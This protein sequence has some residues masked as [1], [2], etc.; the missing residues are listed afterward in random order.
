[1]YS[2]E[3]NRIYAT[4]EAGY[5]AAQVHGFAIISR[6]MD[7]LWDYADYELKYVMSDRRYWAP[8]DANA[9]YE[10]ITDE[11]SDGMYGELSKVWEGDAILEEAR[12]VARAANHQSAGPHR[13]LRPL[14][15]GRRER[16][17]MIGRR[18][19][20]LAR[21]GPAPSGLPSLRI[22]EPKKKN[23]SHIVPLCWPRWRASRT[24]GFH[25]V[26][27]RISRSAPSKRRGRQRKS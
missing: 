12:R 15:H 18:I 10:E 26:L 1:M 3:T 6:L 8:Q 5:R 22:A 2:I 16:S 7:L 23:L 11:E 14:H 25:H 4:H 27:W 13:C 17:G 19:D 21:I 20:R 9:V 24:P